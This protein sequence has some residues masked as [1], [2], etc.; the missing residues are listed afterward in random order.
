[1]K[2]TIYRIFN[3]QNNYIGSTTQS[4]QQRLENH[5]ISYGLWSLNNFKKGYLSSF[6]ILKTKDYQIEEIDSIDI[7]L[8]ENKYDKKELIKLEKFYI[9]N[10]NCVNIQ[11]NKEKI[12][13]KINKELKQTHLE[14]DLTYFIN[15]ANEYCNNKPIILYIKEENI[16]YKWKEMLN[17]NF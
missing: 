17:L 7:F 14:L 4:L 6:E 16:N 11:F 13:K 3:K 5:E 1:M 10:A 12:N 8:K 9:N 2:G 15:K